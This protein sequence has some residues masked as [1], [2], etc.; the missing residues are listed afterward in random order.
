MKNLR[1][2]Q[3]VGVQTLISTLEAKNAHL[4]QRLQSIRAEENCVRERIAN[5]NSKVEKA[6]K[7]V[8]MGLSLSLASA[9]Q[10][11][12]A[13]HLAAV[14]FSRDEALRELERIQSERNFT[15]NQMLTM[16]TIAAECRK[17]ECE[18]RDYAV[19]QKQVATPFF[20]HAFGQKYQ[21]QVE[22]LFKMLF[23]LRDQ[24]YEC[25]RRRRWVEHTIHQLRMRVA[26]VVSAYWK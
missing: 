1:D 6:T 16:S 23:A 18:K 3:L 5:L 9:K 14:Q 20:L 24:S 7:T 13:A 15:Q 11:R 10:A 22:G 19:C 2:Q 21:L 8:A 4:V 26:L 17:T 25:V 12:E